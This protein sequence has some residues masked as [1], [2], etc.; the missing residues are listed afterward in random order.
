MCES[1]DNRV[2]CY[3]TGPLFPR[4]RVLIHYAL[5]LSL[6]SIMLTLMHKFKPSLN[7]MKAHPHT[8]VIKGYIR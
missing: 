6:K 5:A 1:E 7:D 2:A 3:N 4:S 8:V